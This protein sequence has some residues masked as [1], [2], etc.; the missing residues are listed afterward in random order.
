MCPRG[1]LVLLRN[2]VVRSGSRLD[3]SRRLCRH[4]FWSLVT[5]ECDGFADIGLD[6]ETCDF[7]S[8]SGVLGDGC[9]QMRLVHVVMLVVRFIEGET[10]EVDS[11][12]RELRRGME[13]FCLEM[14][15]IEVF[16][17]W[18]FWKTCR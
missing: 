16:K 6:G 5:N 10:S 9:A 11:L 15:V 4:A 13:C 7:E 1:K 14:T 8:Q 18:L 12:R 3:G 17:D 2:L